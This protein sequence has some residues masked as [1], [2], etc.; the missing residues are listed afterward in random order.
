LL[1]AAREGRAPAQVVVDRAVGSDALADWTRSTGVTFAAGSP[2][3]WDR[4]PAAAYAD[5]IDLLTGLRRDDMP[6]VE[7]PRLTRALALL[8]IALG[9]HV[10]ATL[11]TW[12]FTHTRFANV[13]R[14]LVPIAQAA[15]A[16]AATPQTAAADIVRVHA[17][18]RH[19]AGLAAPQDA[20]PVLARAAPALA[21]L[22]TGAL[23]T[24]TWSA[25]AWTVDIAPLD[26]ATL[27]AFVARLAGVGLS[28]LH[29][30][31]SSG[32]RARIAP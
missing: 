28:A 11:G 7:A 19:R 2:W 20:M 6:P 30:R 13:Q 5:A 8:G 18:A 24:A 3:Q 31:T 10:L 27:D 21:A 29:A 14:D 15:G 16:A 23:R 1:Q 17:D 9:V 25:G 4:A 26:D 32:V 22:P 12:G